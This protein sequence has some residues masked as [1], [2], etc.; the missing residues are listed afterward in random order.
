M[1]Y[2]ETPGTAIELTHNWGEHEYELGTGFGHVALGVQDVHAAAA[3][4]EAKGVEL[5]RPAGP[6][7]GGDEII[8]FLRDP[9]G[10]RIELVESHR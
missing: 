9:D 1:G 6:M 10:Y 5:I 7:K 4:L 8:A 3:T 2:D